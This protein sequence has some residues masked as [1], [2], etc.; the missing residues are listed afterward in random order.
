MEFNRRD[1]LKATAAGERLDGADVLL[2][3]GKVA[4]VGR[5]LSVPE[6][7]TRVDATGRESWWRP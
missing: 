3:D 4:A 7:A 6:G 5:G 1:L 2:A